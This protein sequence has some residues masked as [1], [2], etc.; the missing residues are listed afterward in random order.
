M[1]E[2]ALWMLQRLEPANGVSNEA[3]AFAVPGRLD[4]AVLAERV[5]GLVRRH[6]ALR[7]TF[8]EVRGEPMAVVHPV[9]AVELAVVT[10]AGPVSG[11]S[12]AVTDFVSRPFRVEH[13]PPIRAA[14]WRFPDRDVCCV[15]LHHLVYDA[16]TAG[17]LFEELMTGYNAVVAGAALPERLTAVASAWV[18]PAPDD[19]GLAYWRA[20]V[21]GVDTDVQRLA[22]GRPDPRHPTFAGTSRQHM[23]SPAAL[24]SIARL[25]AKY[26]VTENIILFAAYC[27]LLDRHG[28][29]PDPAVGVSVA[30][31]DHTVGAVV[32]YHVNTLPMRV[33]L[34]GLNTF[35][36]VVAAARDTFLEGLSHRHVPYEAVLPELAEL[37]G[38]W[39]APLFRYMFNYRPIPVPAA[40]RLGD[41]PVELLF[42]H[43]RH[44]RHDLEFI[45]ETGHGDGWIRTVYSTE[46]FDD[47]DI[48]SLQE[49]YDRLLVSLA[50]QPGPVA[51]VAFW[52][53]TDEELVAGANRTEVDIPAVPLAGAIAEHFTGPL[54][55][56][57]AI[58]DGAAQVTYAEL[59]VV[60]RGQRDRLVAAGVRAGDV[61]ALYAER[62][63]ALAA[64]V[65]AVW[66][67]GAA[68]LPLH[69]D[70]PA[71]LIR[72]QLTDSGAVA[73]LADR[74]LP[75][76][77][78]PSCAV[79]ALTGP[80]ATGQEAL[81][82]SAA[83]H[84]MAYVIYT[85][86]STGRPKGVAVT[87][88]NLVNLVRHFENTLEF[89]PGDAG[90]WLTSFAF[91]ISALELFLPLTA[92]GRVVVA[93]DRARAD[94]DVIVDLVRRHHVCVVQ[95]T[96][97]TWA[98]ATPEAG[99]LAGTRVLCGGEPLSESLAR[100]L[101]ASG[102]R[103]FNVYGPTETTI[104]STLA[105]HVAGGPVTIGGPIANTSVFVEGPG[106]RPAPPGVTGELCIGGRGVATGYLN[107]PDLTADR[108]RTTATGRYYRTGDR[109]RW[110]HDGALELLGRSDRQVKVRSHRIELGEV[111]A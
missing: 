85:S 39:R 88:D 91:D 54:S 84:D 94:A 1:K 93:P 38:T 79:L 33:R 74:P 48:R 98:S 71:E 44:S 50:E 73:V 31:R 111:E 21:L 83:P 64:A 15:V 42:A 24:D 90:L 63:A 35:A 65:L 7:T 49:R 92:G 52:T 100:D 107:R 87:H 89:G 17:L 46:I 10:V 6:P 62:G 97:T 20:H 57:V 14:L 47:E 99:A 2:R 109:A 78:D 56:A 11:E 68:Y 32:G 80:P 5:R 13:E 8:P 77:S 41:L 4:A 70:H 9:V 66:S 18:E 76:G 29:G 67:V 61:V 34:T 45:V 110:R 60:M 72:F 82:L 96:P 40:A 69:R 23:F 55:D 19:A 58:V 22:M 104:W 37:P 27:L 16:Q 3:L 51:D 30:G 101:L 108:F 75:T 106:G 105:E 53:R 102:C 86:G 36:D 103:L 25:T 95:A 26:H 12:D 43:P 59:A 81:P 28:A